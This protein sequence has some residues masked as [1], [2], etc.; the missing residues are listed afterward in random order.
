[1]SSLTGTSSST[2]PTCPSRS[3]KGATVFRNRSSNAGAWPMPWDPE[4][5]DTSVPTPPNDR[6]LVVLLGCSLLLALEAGA[7]FAAWRLG[8][9]SFLGA[10]LAV[11][12][13]TTRPLLIRVAAVLAQL[14]LALCIVP[15]LRIASAPLFALAVCAGIAAVGPIYPP[16]ALVVWQA[17]FGNAG[18]IAGA[19]HAAW[20]ITS[21]AALGGTWAVIAV[22][23]RRRAA[24]PSASHG[25]A[26]WGTGEA[27]AGERGLLLGRS[28]RHVLR[29]DGQGHVLTVAPTR[30]GKG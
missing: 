17:R 6:P 14:A 2:V 7:A 25:S 5:H 8:S 20:L 9:P 21:V 29:L 18:D 23:R 10:P 12:S 24:S 13:P 15:R 4:E 26:R 30:S 22:W 27:L 1:M 19:L 3:G 28:E 16:H 11:V